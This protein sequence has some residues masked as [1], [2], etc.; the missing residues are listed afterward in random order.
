MEYLLLISDILKQGFILFG[1]VLPLFFLLVSSL[2]GS[3]FKTF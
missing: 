3:T 2:F 1:F